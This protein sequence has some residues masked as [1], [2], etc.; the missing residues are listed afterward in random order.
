[1]LSSS[2]L[3]ALIAMGSSTLTSYL[4]NRSA[5]ELEKFKLQLQSQNDKVKKRVQTY[6][7]LAHDLDSLAS[8]LD[9]YLRMST[10]AAKAPHDTLSSAS[11]LVQRN[12][13]GLAEKEV[14]SANKDISPYDSELASE[15]DD[16]LGKLSPALATAQEN[17]KASASLSDVLEQL[18]QLISRANDGMDK[19]LSNSRFL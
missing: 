1:L 7:A 11:L 14:L 19:S 18:K 13:V 2:V 8:V 3:A 6:S 10:I 12:K 17:P 9:A 4:N 5:Q 16:C 15:V